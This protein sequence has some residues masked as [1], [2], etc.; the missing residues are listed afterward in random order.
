MPKSGVTRIVYSGEYYLFD[1]WKDNLL[2]S[3][4]WDDKMVFP[5]SE[6]DKYRPDWTT[7]SD[8]PSASGGVLV[9]PDGSTTAQQ[10]STASGF[11][12]G[13]WEKDF[14]IISAT[15]AGACNLFFIWTDNSNTLRVSIESDDDYMLVKI[16]GGTTT[17]L[18][19]STWD[20]DTTQ[21]TTKV[22]RDANGN[23][24]LFYDG[25]SQGTA[26]DTFL[27]STRDLSFL[28][29]ADSEVDIDNL[30]VY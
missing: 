10:V 26:T 9:L 24:E 1:D 20:G 28:N 3:R 30:K 15:T 25:V 27:P 22:T 18:V 21:H 13:T 14:T 7:E 12:V 8:S 11:T 19:S 16:D 17:I 2:T 29:N 4:R 6:L 5:V 23:F